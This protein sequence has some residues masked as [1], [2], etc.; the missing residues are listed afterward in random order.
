M[1]RQHPTRARPAADFQPRT[2]K[3]TRSAG[4]TP[5]PS[6]NVRLAATVNA[7]MAANPIR[8]FGSSTILLPVISSGGQWSRAARRPGHLVARGEPNIFEPGIHHQR[9]DGLTRPAMRKTPEHL[10]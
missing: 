1:I 5:A 10:V 2:P 8:V 7:I 6:F 4:G 9:N 3:S